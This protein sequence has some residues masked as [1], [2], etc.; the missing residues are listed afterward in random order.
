MVFRFHNDLYPFPPSREDT[1]DANMVEEESYSSESGVV[2]DDD[3]PRKK[4][5]KQC[6]IM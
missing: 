5:R 1:E 4:K 2:G 6:A 3:E